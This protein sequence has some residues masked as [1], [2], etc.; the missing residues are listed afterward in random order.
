MPID[1]IGRVN[2]FPDSLYRQHIGLIEQLDQLKENRRTIE[3]DSKLSAAQKAQEKAA[4]DK[5]VASVNQ[6]LLLPPTFDLHDP[7]DFPVL[8]P[9]EVKLLDPEKGVLDTGDAALNAQV[10]FERWGPEG[11]RSGSLHSRE[12]LNDK[13]ADKLPLAVGGQELV[14][15][16]D[17][18][19]SGIA[20]ARHDR[21]DGVVEIRTGPSGKLEGREPYK[22]HLPATLTVLGISADGRIDPNNRADRSY[23]IM[24][25]SHTGMWQYDQETVYV[26][27][28]V[29]QSDL[30]MAATQATSRQT[31]QVYTEP[32]RTSEIHVKL[33]P[34]ADPEA[35]KIEAQKIVDSVLAEQRNARMARGE[36]FDPAIDSSEVRVETWRESGAKYIDAIEHEKVLVVVL[37]SIISVVAIF[38]IF[39]IFYMIVAEKTKDIGIIKS[40]GATDSAVAGIFLGYGLVIGI[41]GGGL[42]LLASYFIIHNIN[43]LHSA[44]AGVMGVRIW[45]P[46]VYAFDKIPNTMDPHETAVIVTIAVLSSVLAL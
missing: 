41:V 10:W 36:T 18:T 15:G 39:C 32:A 9:D 44:M 25:D 8:L 43:E 1:Q 40:V 20:M 31:G 7:V 46:E 2:N 24:D 28:D 6:K 29:L 26:P 33:K 16:G 5:E 12:P 30:G 34:V 35:V 37:F 38:L 23:W 3:H 11:S 14:Q 42:V 21:F 4:I 19:G 22:H 17:A 13:E 45:S 27:F